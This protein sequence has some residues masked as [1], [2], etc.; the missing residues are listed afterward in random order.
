MSRTEAFVGSQLLRPDY[1]EPTRSTNPERLLNAT[2][3]QVTPTPGFCSR[4]GVVAYG[5]ETGLWRE[6]ALRL[7][8]EL[9]GNDDVRRLITPAVAFI[10]FQDCLSPWVLLAE[11]LSTTQETLVR[12]TESC[13][14]RQGLLNVCAGDNTIERE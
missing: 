1:R 8:V 5:V 4:Q 10:E 9:S 11:S 13:L 14:E 7:L 3:V 2:L 12:C 6:D